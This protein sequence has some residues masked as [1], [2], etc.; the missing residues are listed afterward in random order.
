M[1]SNHQELLSI[2]AQSGVLYLL[3]QEKMRKSVLEQY[4]SVTFMEGNVQKS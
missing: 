1:V 3:T 2:K 4:F